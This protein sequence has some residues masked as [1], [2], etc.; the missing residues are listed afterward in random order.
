MK[1]VKIRMYWLV[2]ARVNKARF[3]LGRRAAM[4]NAVRVVK[5]EQ[6]G[7]VSLSIGS[8]NVRDVNE[9]ERWRV[10]GYGCKPKKTF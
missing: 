10:C 8:V 4:V 5:R 3:R 7:I 6:R 1:S 2:V 9:G